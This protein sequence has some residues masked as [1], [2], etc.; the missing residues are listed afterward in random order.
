[1]AIKNNRKSM[2]MKYFC[3]FFL[4]FRRI[5]VLLQSRNNYILK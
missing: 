1:M 5:V 3:D 2:I 4:S